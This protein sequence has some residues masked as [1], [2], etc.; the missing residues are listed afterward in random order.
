M[1]YKLRPIQTG[2]LASVL[3]IAVLSP[4][5]VGAQV[6]NYSI[7]SSTKSLAAGSAGA[8]LTARVGNSSKML[9][10]SLCFATG[11]GSSAPIIPNSPTFSGGYTSVSID[12]PAST[13]QQ[14]PPDAFT[15]GVFSASLY[16]VPLSATSCTGP[17]PSTSAKIGLIYPHLSG[18]SLTSVPQANPNLS[19]R[20]PSNITLTGSSFLNALAGASGSASSVTFASSSSPGVSYTGAVRPISATSLVSSIPSSISGSLASIGV[21]VCNSTPLYSY[22]SNALDLALSPLASDTGTATATPNVALLTQNV[23]V[24]ASFG[25]SKPSLAGAPGGLV[26]FTDGQTVL[27]TA[28]LTLDSTAR[29]I[30]PACVSFVGSSP[31]AYPLLADLNQDGVP[32]VLI[33]DPAANL[34]HLFFGS[35]PAATFSNDRPIKPPTTGAAI[36]DAAVGDFNRDGFPD[37]AILARPAG[38]AANSVYLLLNDGS[39]NFAAPTLTSSQVFGSHLLAADFN[40]DGLAD[41]IV[42]GALGTDGATGLQVL[43]GDGAGDFAPGPA[44]PGLNTSA[45]SSFGGFQIAIADFNGDGF[46]DIAV[47]NGANSSDTEISK[48]IA[49]FQNDGTARFAAATTVPTDGTASVYFAAAPLALHQL[50]ALLITSSTGV[51]VAQN[52]SAATINFLTSMPFTAI[53]GLK[54]AVFGDFNADGFIDAA[55][56]NGKSVYVLNGDGAGSFKVTHPGLSFWSFPDIALFAATDING[57]TYSDLMSLRTDGQSYRLQGYLAAGTASAAISSGS[58][59]PGVHS[60]VANTPGTSYLA[61]ASATATLTIDIPTSVSITSSVPSSVTYGQAVTL[62]ATIPDPTATGTIAFYNGAKLLGSAPL[63]DSTSATA[64]FITASLAAGKYAVRAVYSGDATHATATSPA[65]SFAVLQTSPNLA[66]PT[67]AGIIAGTALS[68]AQLDASATGVDGMPLSGTYTYTPALGTIEAAGTQVLKVI[69]TPTDLNDYTTTSNSVSITVVPFTVSGLSSSLALLG[70]PAKT[71][72]I[73]GTG[74]FPTAVALMNGSPLPTTY[75][76]STAISA[77][78]PASDFLT[79]RT[80]QVSV[81]DSAQSATSQTLPFYVVAPIANVIF[82]GPTSIVPGTQISL[83]FQLTNPYPVPLTATFSLGFAPLSG[84]PSDPNIV[85]AD[86]GSTYQVVIPANSTASPQVLIQT[87]TIAGT[88]TVGLD[89]MAGGTDV[90]PSSVHPLDIQAPVSVPGL[91]SVSSTASGRT[92]TVTVHGFSNTREVKTATFHFAPAPGH[93]LST[94]DVT[95]DVSSIF[96][97]WY[98]DPASDQYGSSFTYTQVFDLTS[99][100]SVVGQVSVV[101]ENSVGTSPPAV[102]Q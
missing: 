6:L 85:F 76:S 101:L 23:M 42:A 68:S 99:D 77:V 88:L 1:R 74:F 63:V 94:S 16:A 98:A 19:T 83:T 96:A 13:I 54:K 62:S 15:N 35:S 31:A 93:T 81:S 47:L 59:A 22:C 56:D 73:S 48:L 27:G 95:I 41:L 43:F 92:L 55:V 51:S 90:T 29:F 26:S 87:G 44:T 67:P 66:W 14:V 102:S 37:L 21:Q 65:V 33:T 53:P 20:L 7:T 61:G 39:G 18:I 36:L 78:L 75:L 50:P 46:P 58:L 100:A 91:T 34:I 3:T 10:F 82:T 5:V 28:A 2:L 72:T 80:L 30:A 64:Q 79:V 71:I 89:L 84:L 86:S 97:A 45:S 12:V 32:D 69:F 17:A 4:Y 25:A 60:V 49:I 9:D 24:S 57:D 8:S 52:Q 40:H 38:A 11:Y 70:E